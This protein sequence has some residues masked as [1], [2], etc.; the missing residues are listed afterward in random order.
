[1]A[2]D[3]MTPN[4]KSISALASVREAADFLRKHGIHTAPVID[5]AGRPVG[6]LSRTDLL[7]LWSRGPER[8]AAIAA[9]KPTIG[10]AGSL[11]DELPVCYGRIWRTGGC[12]ER[13]RSAKNVVSW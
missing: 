7:D 4:P 11:P 13:F 8:L 12:R 10:A 3:V 2:A 9:G 6:V 5:E 1:M